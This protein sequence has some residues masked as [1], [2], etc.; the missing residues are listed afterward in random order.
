MGGYQLTC[1]LRPNLD[2]AWK[3]ALE[4]LNKYDVTEFTDLS[5]SMWNRDPFGTPDDV[6]CNI[7]VS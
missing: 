2:Q 6:I 1:S 5:Q 7:E 4:F 3:E